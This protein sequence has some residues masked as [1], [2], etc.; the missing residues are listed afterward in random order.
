MPTRAAAS[1]RFD[2]Q[3]VVGLPDVRSREQILKV[4]MRRVPRARYRRQFARSTDFSGADLANLVNKLLCSPLAV[5]SAWCPWWVRKR[6]QIMMGAE[7]RS[8]VMTEAQKEST[9]YHE[10]TRYWPP[11][12]GHDRC[13]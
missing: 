5:T 6:R 3:V 11:G 8:M 12:T 13:W 4:H 10:A 2:R 1:S 9:A 7:R